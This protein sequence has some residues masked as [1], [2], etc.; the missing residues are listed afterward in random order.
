[1][2]MSLRSD[3]QSGITHSTRFACSGRA[4]HLSPFT[5]PLLLSLLTNHFSLLTAASAAQQCASRISSL[6]SHQALC[7]WRLAFVLPPSPSLRRGKLSSFSKAVV[8]SKDWLNSGKAP[9][10]N[11]T[12]ASGLKVSSRHRS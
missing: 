11:C 9:F 2:V 1:M 4:L 8:S 5:N 6:H 10:P 12:Y 7:V 3:Y